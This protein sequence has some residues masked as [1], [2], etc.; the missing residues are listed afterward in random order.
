MIQFLRFDKS[1][2]FDVEFEIIKGKE[3]VKFFLKRTSLSFSFCLF[4]TLSG[5]SNTFCKNSMFIYLFCRKYGN[6]FLSDKIYKSYS[7]IFKI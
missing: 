3:A 4:Y 1:K 5:S 6:C 2:E 7:K